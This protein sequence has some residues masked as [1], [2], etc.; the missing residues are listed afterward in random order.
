MIVKLTA[1]L[2]LVSLV[3]AAED[4][5]ATQPAETD[6]STL[7]RW[8][9]GSFSSE[10]QSR[11]NPSYFDIRLEM[12]PIWSH[13]S[14][15]LWL[16][17]EQARADALDRPYRQRIYELVQRPGGE[18]ES[19][20]YELPGDDPLKFAGAWKDPRK[21]DG[22]KKEDL[23]LKQGCSIFLRRL[24]DGAY[25]GATRGNGCASTRQGAAYTTSEVTVSADR[26][27]SWDRGWDADGKQVWGATEGGYVFRR[28]ATA[29]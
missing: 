11:E 22:V 3:V 7:Y 18:F 6:Y 15:S 14:D 19:R 27:I 26:I 28:V 23:K 17:V 8:L 12:A 1:L 21:L 13:R 5:P 2:L 4:P 16:Y 24:P 10:Q 20:V 9:S 29:R 25:Q